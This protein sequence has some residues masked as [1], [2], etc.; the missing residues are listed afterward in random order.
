MKKFVAGLIVGAA[1]MIS[2]QAIA[3]TTSLVGKKILAENTVFV[4]GEE[5][6]VKAVNIGGTTYTPNRAIANAL[7]QDIEFKNNEVQFT[8]RPEVVFTELTLQEIDDKI[9]SAKSTIRGYEILLQITHEEEKIPEINQRIAEQ[10]GKV[11]S[12]QE[13]RVYVESQLQSQQ[14]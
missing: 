11:T 9:Q 10:N 14:Q 2:G 1:L 7:N 6:P 12:L 3:E 13:A 5:L 8:S 4:D